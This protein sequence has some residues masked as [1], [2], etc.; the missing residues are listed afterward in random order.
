[1][2][3]KIFLY[4]KAKELEYQEIIF[5]KKIKNGGLIYYLISRLLRK[6]PLRSL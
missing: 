4:G 1:M 3:S 2:I 6:L 5:K